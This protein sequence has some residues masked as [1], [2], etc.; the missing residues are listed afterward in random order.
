[1]EKVIL[2]DDLDGSTNNVTTVLFAYKGND[3]R[4]DLSEDNE[5]ALDQALERY[6]AAAQKLPGKP[7]RKPS[8]PRRKAAPAPQPEA[9]WQEGE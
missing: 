2:V 6:V 7:G 5:R 3:Y 9:T 1:M 8:R 4:I